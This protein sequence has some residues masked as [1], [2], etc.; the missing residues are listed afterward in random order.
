MLYAH[1]PDLCRESDLRHAMA[2]CFEALIG[3]LKRVSPVQLNTEVRVARIRS[4]LFSISGL[5]LLTLSLNYEFGCLL[6][7]T[8]L[9][10][11]FTCLSN[12]GKNHHFVPIPPFPPT[13]PNID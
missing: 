12:A 10:L 13:Q 4:E 6:Y 1:G 7:F 2:N 5:W 3:N 8:R 9:L 11:Y